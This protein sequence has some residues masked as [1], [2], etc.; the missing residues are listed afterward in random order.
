VQQTVLLLLLVV[1]MVV[2]C[3]RS[4]LQVLQAQMCWLICGMV[5]CLQLQGAG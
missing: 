1:V 4:Q 3:F 2:P 5:L